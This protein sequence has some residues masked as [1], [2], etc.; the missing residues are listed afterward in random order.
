M[1]KLACFLLIGFVWGVYILRFGLSF[2]VEQGADVWGQFGDF[3]GGVLNPI[4]SFTSICLLIRSVNFQL[5]SNKTLSNEIKRQENLENY[6][7]FEVRFFSLLDAQ[8][9]N[10][11]R[12]RILLEES[13][14]NVP[15]IDQDEHLVYEPIQTE[16]KAGNAVSY[17]DDCLSVLVKGGIEKNRITSWLED[18]D[19]DDHLFSLVRRFFLLTKLIN[20]KYSGDKNEQFELLISL[21]DDKL[22][23]MIAIMTDYYDWDNIKYIKSSN[24]LNIAGLNGYTSSYKN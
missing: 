15:V 23:T 4:L 19:V 9:S 6:K 18:L 10:F 3:M 12:F 14:G 16:Y 7:R 2:L 11:T 8:Q 22:L 21:T 5:E 20:E 13:Q 17:I 24:I 1:I